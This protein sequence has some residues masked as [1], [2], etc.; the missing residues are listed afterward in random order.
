M[1][2]KLTTIQ[3]ITNIQPI[4]GADRIVQA[5]VMGWTVVVGKEHFKNGDLCVFFEVDSLLP[6]GKEWS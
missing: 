5:T 6:D 1:E 3:Q 4:A 2:R